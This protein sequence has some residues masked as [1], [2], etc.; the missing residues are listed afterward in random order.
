MV[1]LYKNRRGFTLLEMVLVIAIILILWF[2]A[3]KVDTGEMRTGEIVALVSYM[4]Q[5]LLAMIVVANLVTI[6][7]R[8]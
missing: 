7:T 5:I 4:T 3:V 8:K 1:V 2:G 6:M